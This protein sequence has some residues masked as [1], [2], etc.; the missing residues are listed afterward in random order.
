MRWGYHPRVAVQGP[1]WVQAVRSGAA[2]LDS[3]ARRRELTKMGQ[4]ETTGV[5]PQVY[6][7]TLSRCLRL[8]D[9]LLP[10]FGLGG[11]DENFASPRGNREVG[12]GD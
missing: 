2:A 5:P 1:L 4:E 11:H 6:A 10:R 12:Q 9:T 8:T 3:A 7:Q